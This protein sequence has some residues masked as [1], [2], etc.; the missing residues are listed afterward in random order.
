MRS[1]PDAILQSAQATYLDSLTPERDPLLLEMEHLAA[2]EGQP[3]ADPEVAQLLR[4]LLRMRQPRRV[5]EVGT[6]IGYSVVVMGRELPADAV[7]ETIE[8]KPR[9]VAVAREF[10][11][12]AALQPKVIVHE[13]AALEVMERLTGQFD[14]VFIDC[15]K[16]EYVDYLESVLPKMSAGGV[17]VADNVL[18]KGKVATGEHD[19]DTDGI[20]AFNERI[21]SHPQLVSSVLPIGDGISLSVVR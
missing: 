3:I 10:A 16:Y 18:W 13:G 1:K 15:L 20:R 5:L 6:N 7:I 14:L 8:I 2:E 17:I 12:R 4:A 11:K 19:R 9:L 21:M